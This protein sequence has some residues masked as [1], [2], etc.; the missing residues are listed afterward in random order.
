MPPPPPDSRDA[1]MDRVRRML[2]KDHVVRKRIVELNPRH[3]LVRGL[4]VR[5]TA[6][7]D[8]LVNDTIEQLY[9][10]ALLLEGLHPNSAEMVGRIQ[11]LMERAVKRE[12]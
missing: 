3:V 7:D 6:G 10:N 11:A 9:A 1:E 12:A 8:D 2:E 4:T 5:L